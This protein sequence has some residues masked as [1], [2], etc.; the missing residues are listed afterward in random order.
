MLTISSMNPSRNSRGHLPVV[1]VGG[2]RTSSQIANS[3]M[4]IFILVAKLPEFCL[5]PKAKGQEPR[6]P[7][8]MGPSAED[9][10]A[11]GQEPKKPRM[12]RTM[13]AYRKKEGQQH[14]AARAANSARKRHLPLQVSSPD[15]LLLQGAF[16][17]TTDAHHHADCL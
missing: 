10:R 6:K 2:R 13:D 9:L 16:R 8:A 12:P 1:H 4:K 11:K 14:Q 3:K 5:K 7:R 15:R 17:A